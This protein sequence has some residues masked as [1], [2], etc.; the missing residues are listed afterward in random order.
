[1]AAPTQLLT[2]A[3]F[4]A[5]AIEIAHCFHAT[6]ASPRDGVF[7]GEAYALYTRE[8]RVK[9]LFEALQAGVRRGRDIAFVA[10]S[11]VESGRGTTLLWRLAP[12]QPSSCCCWMAC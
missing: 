3:E 8:S 5:L 1:M 12:S 7:H 10:V 9:E 4:A 6:V 11:R 2:D